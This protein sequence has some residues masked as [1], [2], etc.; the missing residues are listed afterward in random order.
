M[1]NAGVQ[2]SSK[3]ILLGWIFGGLIQLPFFVGTPTLIPFLIVQVIALL[4]V[5]LIVASVNYYLSR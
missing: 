3:F 4:V 2:R 5:C 1:Q